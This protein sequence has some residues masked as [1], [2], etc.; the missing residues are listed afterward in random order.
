MRTKKETK[1][2]WH[3]EK[4]MQA[5]WVMPEDAKVIKSLAKR[6]GT[7]RTAIISLMLNMTRGQF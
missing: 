1:G 2:N 3:R 7:S 6:R 5:I 4:K